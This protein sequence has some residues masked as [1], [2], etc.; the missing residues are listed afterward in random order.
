MLRNLIVLVH[1]IY[2]V[3]R[4]IEAVKLA[5]SFGIEKFIV[6]R[7]IGAAAQEAYPE[8]CKIALRLNRSILF[9]R[10]LQDVIE[11]IKPEVAIGIV[12]PRYANNLFSEEEV[13]KKLLEGKI[14]LLAFG[15]GEPGFTRKD[16]E[17]LDARTLDVPPDIPN[18]GLM[19]IT[20][21][22]VTREYHRRVRG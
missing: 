9:L 2:S 19:A 8:A 20:L 18:L 5:Y 3:T 14:V 13:V 15:G 16:L 11:T 22:K 7:A 1:N 4:L 21:Y 6:T 10:D 12:P 17:L